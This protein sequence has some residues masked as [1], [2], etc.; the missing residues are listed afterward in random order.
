MIAVFRISAVALASLC[1]FAQSDATLASRLDETISS[2]LAK[3]GAPSVSVAVVQDGKSVYV[4]AFGKAN[5]ADDKPATANTRYAI[6]SVSKQFTAAAILLLQEQG[7]LSID[8]KVAKY[9]PNLTRANEVSIRQLLS[10]TAGYEDY[11]PQDYI[12]P[13][14]QQPTT[15]QAILDKWAKKPLNFDPGTRYQ[16]SNTGYVLAAS[17]VEKVA[18]TPLLDFLRQHILDPL[19]MSSAGDC[20]KRSPDDA[21][22]YTRFALGPP[23]PVAR[24][25]AGWYDGAGELCMTA[26]DLSKWDIAFIEKKIL[27]PKS[28]E[29]FTKEVKLND[30]KPTHYGLGISLGEAFGGPVYAHS[31]EVSGFLASNQI[32]PARRAAIVVL[33]NQDGINVIFPLAQ[34]LA[35][36]VVDPEEAAKAETESKEIREILESLVKGRINRTLFTPNANAYFTERA[37]E[38]YRSSLSKLGKLESVTKVNEQLRGGMRHLSYRAQFAKKSVSLNIYKTNDGKYEQFL[39]VE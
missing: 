7:K 36:M 6:G 17:I 8:D 19:G 20:S 22:A 1:A 31:G 21:T 15:S 28:Y 35:S 26:G 27:A 38:D 3:S 12:I 16:Y 4:K 33:S 11:A 30:G 13:E 29:E 9:F 10:H 25:G 14:W 39:V 23:R 32:Y 2:A 18:G 34:K 37:L 24:E 5:I